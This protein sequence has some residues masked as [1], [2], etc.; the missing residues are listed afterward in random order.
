MPRSVI[1]GGLVILLLV[2]GYE[3]YTFRVRDAADAAVCKGWYHA[4]RT[5]ADS[6]RIDI[7]LAP[8]ARSGAEMATPNLTCGELRRSGRIQ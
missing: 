2:A 1:V 4:A 8:R 6:T 5:R 3:L 7:Q